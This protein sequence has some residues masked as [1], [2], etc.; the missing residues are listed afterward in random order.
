MTVEITQPI[1]F[2]KAQGKQ[3]QQGGGAFLRCDTPE[4]LQKWVEM[5]QRCYAPAKFQYCENDNTVRIV[6]EKFDKA[7][8]THQAAMRNWTNSSGKLD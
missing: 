5:I 4:Q 8:E 1:T 7:E 6:S 3:L 2:R